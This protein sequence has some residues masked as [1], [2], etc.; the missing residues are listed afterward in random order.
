MRMGPEQQNIQLSS[1]TDDEIHRT[2]TLIVRLGGAELK[3][4]IT[5]NYMNLKQP[6]LVQ[7]EEL[8]VR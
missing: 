1:L 2:I 7:P 6:E 3:C 4:V 8:R 5:K